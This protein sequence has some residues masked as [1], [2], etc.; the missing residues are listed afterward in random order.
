MFSPEESCGIL[1]LLALGGLWFIIDYIDR[2]F[3]LNL[4]ENKKIGIVWIICILFWITIGIIIRL[5]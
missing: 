2:K 5:Y 1:P 4:S 3:K